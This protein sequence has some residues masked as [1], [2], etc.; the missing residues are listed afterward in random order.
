HV[1]SGLMQVDWAGRWQKLALKEDKTLILDSTH[2]PEGARFLEEALECL[3]IETQKKPVIITG[4]LG[5]E[6][7]AAL[8]PVIG[9]WASELYLVEPAQPRALTPAGLRSFLSGSQAE[10]T[11]HQ[12]SLAQL[13]PSCDCCRA[14]QSGDT[15]VVVGSIYLIGEV[16]QR[17]QDQD[18][19]QDTLQDHP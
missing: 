19:S 13:F 2:N 1:H 6:R 4:I 10:L 12:R 15:V 11:T 16:L 18:S 17:L 8:M 5:E 3:T 7:A 9:R 14:G